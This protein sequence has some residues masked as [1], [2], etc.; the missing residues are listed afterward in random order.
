MN[1]KSTYKGIRLNNK[2]AAPMTKDE[3]DEKYLF[4][5]YFLNW[6]NLWDGMTEVT[7]KLTKET[8]TALK[9]TTTAI[10]QITDYCIDELNMKYILPGKFQ[11]DQLEARFG[12]YRQLAGC[13]YNISVRQVFECEQKLRMMSVLRIPFHNQSVDLKDFEEAKWEKMDNNDLLNIHRFDIEVTQ[14]DIEKCMEYLQVITY[15][16]G[17]CCFAVSKKM[18][19]E[20]CKDLLTCNEDIDSLPDNHNYIQGISRGALLYPDDAVVNI[21]MYNYIVLTKLTQNAEFSKSVNQRNVAM[22]ISLNVLIE[23]D[24]FLP[25]NNCDNGHSIDKI[26]KML[27]WAATNALLNNFCAKEND[28]INKNKLSGKKRKLQTLT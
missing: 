17:Y 9:H 11:T 26:K 28:F 22:E 7:G 19:C 8:F 10:L 18:K 16:A 6:L 1:V 23:N 15:L 3:N 2:Y 27:L 21:I 4:M 5:H 14:D 20:F 24:A 13:N 25:M 12:K